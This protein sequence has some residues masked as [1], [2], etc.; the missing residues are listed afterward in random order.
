MKL[1]G[2]NLFE[3]MLRALIKRECRR[4]KTG[5]YIVLSHV[6]QITNS[7]RQESEYVWRLEPKIMKPQWERSEH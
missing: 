6:V 2:K 3:T 7:M 4:R 1:T 5:K